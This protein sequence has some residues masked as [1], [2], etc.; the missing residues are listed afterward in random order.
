MTR[1]GGAIVEAIIFEY[2]KS[3]VLQRLSDPFW[4]QAL[5]AAMGM[6]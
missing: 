2:G 5:G 6:D 1:L 3:S 4:F